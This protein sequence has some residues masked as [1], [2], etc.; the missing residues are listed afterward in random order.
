MAQR[1]SRDF[2][3]TKKGWEE[4]YNP[5]FFAKDVQDINNHLYCDDE[6]TIY[7]NSYFEGMAVKGIYILATEE[8]IN[9]YVK[10]WIELGILKAKED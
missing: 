1:I 7:I 4:G 5:D 8:T 6:H 2:Y 3:I 10:N 9:W